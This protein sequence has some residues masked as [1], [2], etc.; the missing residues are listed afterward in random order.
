MK[1]FVDN[2]PDYM[3]ADQLRS[4]FKRA[5][6]IVTVMVGKDKISAHIEMETTKGGQKAIE[7]FHEM[8]MDGYIIGVEKA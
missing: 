1:L 3:D 8:Q 5:G 4:L 2:F 6:R 7:M